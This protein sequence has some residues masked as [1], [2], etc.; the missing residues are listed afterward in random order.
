MRPAAIE[1]TCI[2]ATSMYCTSFAGLSQ[3]S[4]FQRQVTRSSANVLSALSGAFACAITN[5]S[6][7]SAGRYSTM[8][9][10]LPLRTTRYGVSMKP[11]RFTFA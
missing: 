4:V 5:C 3:N 1:I 6:S 9:V 7:T 11:K 10:T 2:G 8:F